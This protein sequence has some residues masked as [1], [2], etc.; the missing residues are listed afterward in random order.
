MKDGKPQPHPDDKPERQKVIMPKLKPPRH[1]KIPK[2]KTPEEAAFD[3]VQQKNRRKKL[4]D[5]YRDKHEG[6]HRK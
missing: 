3:A 5:K 6:K 1:Y 2:D 4:T